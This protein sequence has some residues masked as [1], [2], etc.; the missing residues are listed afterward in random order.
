V[1][2]KMLAGGVDGG[3]TYPERIAKVLKRM[4]RTYVSIEIEYKD[5]MVEADALVGNA[6]QPTILNSFK[7]AALRLLCAGGLQTRPVPLLRGVNGVLKPGRFTLLLGPPG[8]GKSVLMQALSGRLRYH[9]GLRK[10]GELRYNGVTPDSFCIRRSSG[11]VDQCEIITP[12]HRASGA[13]FRLGAALKKNC[14]E[15]GKR[16]VGI[17]FV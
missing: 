15:K 14:I 2:A 5:L 6:S 8:A 9:Q 11:L 12:Y 7:S 10:S 13:L 3:P 4:Q 16:L 1:A 17:R